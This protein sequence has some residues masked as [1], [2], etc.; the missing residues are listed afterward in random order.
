MKNAKAAFMKRYHLRQQQH[1]T[2]PL[3]TDFPLG[4]SAGEIIIAFCSCHQA[5]FGLQDYEEAVG[6]FKAVLKIEPNNKAAKNQLTLCQHKLKQIKEGEK[7]KYAGMF[8][9]FAS[10]DAKVTYRSFPGAKFVEMSE[11]V[12]RKTNLSSP[13][14]T[15]P[16]PPPSTNHRRDAISRSISQGEYFL[17]Q[18]TVL[19]KVDLEPIPFATSRI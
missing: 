7:K 17:S 19:Q 13:S 8:D 12:S 6:D 9:K 16:P 4:C 11:Y 5:N 15:Y 14:T 10:I 2:V 3:S 1:W 18:F